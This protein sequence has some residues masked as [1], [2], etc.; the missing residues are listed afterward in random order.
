[1]TE[2]INDINLEEKVLFET[3]QNDIAKKR[4]ELKFVSF[5][6]MFFSYIVYIIVDAIF[7]LPGLIDLF[8]SVVIALLIAFGFIKVYNNNSVNEK[9]VITDKTISFYDVNSKKNVNL[10][11]DEIQ[12]F[13]CAQTYLDE[14]I[15][16]VDIRVY[17]KKGEFKIKNISEYRDV[18]DLL[19]DK[20]SFSSNLVE[21]NSSSFLD[22]NIVRGEQIIN[23]VCDEEKILWQG[24][25]RT[26]KFLKVVCYILPFLFFG[27]PMFMVSGLNVSDYLFHIFIVIVLT[28][29]IHLCVRLD[30]I[31]EEKAYYI[32]TDKRIIYTEKQLNGSYVEIPLQTINKCVYYSGTRYTTK[33][34]EIVTSF[35]KYKL[36]RVGS[37]RKVTKLIKKAVEDYKNTAES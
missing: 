11:F 37:W 17:T 27:C 30:E 36:H 6:V 29:F 10:S 24:K 22:S 18:C 3:K 5:F 19:K 13:D 21:N 8:I 1:M 26:L 33:G 35:K 4:D 2:N 34:I 12:R 7:K 32:L 14:K 16:C 23:Q 9:L 31:D 28:T 25:H 20:I 15:N